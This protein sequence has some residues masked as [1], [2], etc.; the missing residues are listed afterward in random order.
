MNLGHVAFQRGSVHKGFETNIAVDFS[1]FRVLLVDFVNV[2]LECELVYRDLAAD[3]A[4]HGASDLL[5][6]VVPIHV[7]PEHGGRGEQL[8]TIGA[9]AF[10]LLVL[11][12]DMVLEQRFCGESLITVGAFLWP[13]SK[14]HKMTLQDKSASYSRLTCIPRE[15]LFCEKSGYL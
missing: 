12:H 6:V 10:V 11:S 4:G 3:V 1:V 8:T 14:H 9:Q 5:G 15:Q 13:E 2:T 7:P